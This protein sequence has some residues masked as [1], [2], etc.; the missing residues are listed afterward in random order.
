MKYIELVIGRTKFEVEFYGDTGRI[1]YIR[2][3]LLNKKSIGLTTDEITNGKPGSYLPIASYLYQDANRELSKY[4]KKY[5][6]ALEKF[7]KLQIYI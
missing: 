1:L 4:G 3:K 2:R 5:L 7:K 6:L